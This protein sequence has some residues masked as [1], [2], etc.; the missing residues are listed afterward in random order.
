[1]FNAG[2]RFEGVFCACWTPSPDITE[3]MSPTAVVALQLALLEADTVP[4]IAC[5]SKA[6][7]PGWRCW[8]TL[9]CSEVV[10]GPDER[11]GHGAPI[12]KEEE[13]EGLQVE[14]VASVVYTNK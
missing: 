1:M 8:G 5:I 4:S 11:P 3:P 9:M 14:D 12:V 7:S 2:L 10:E 13:A 6:P